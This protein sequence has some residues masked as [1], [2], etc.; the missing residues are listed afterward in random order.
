MIGE[1]KTFGFSCL[2][3]TE[4]PIIFPQIVQTE[5]RRIQTKTSVFKRKYPNNII[6]F[7]ALPW[8][9]FTLLYHARSFTWSDSC[10]KI[11]IGKLTDEN[12]KKSMPIS[13]HVHRSLV[14]EYHVGLFIEQ[15]QQLMN[16]YKKH[17]VF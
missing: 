8:I 7:S 15:L 16:K 5:I 1:D 3:Y 9:N 6:H 12:G 4:N 17:K 13:I 14:N 11:S 10:P 2:A